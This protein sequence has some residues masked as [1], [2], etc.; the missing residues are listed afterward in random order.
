MF[1]NNNEIWAGL[2]EGQEDNWQENVIVENL[3]ECHG[4]NYRQGKSLAVLK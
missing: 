2:K 3:K 4:E 1:I